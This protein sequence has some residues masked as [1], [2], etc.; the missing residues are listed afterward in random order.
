VSF[1]FI[2]ELAFLFGLRVVLGAEASCNLDC[3]GKISN[4]AGLLS[5]TAGF[6]TGNLEIS[7]KSVEK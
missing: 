5:G 7:S 4:V 2:E 3:F 1:S 6:A